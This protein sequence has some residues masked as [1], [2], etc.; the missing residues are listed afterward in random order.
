MKKM[1]CPAMKS[2]VSSLVSEWSGPT[3]RHDPAAEPSPYHAVTV[4]SRESS[5]VSVAN[6]WVVGGLNTPVDHL[7]DST[8]RCVVCIPHAG[9]QLHIVSVSF[10]PVS[11]RSC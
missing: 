8:R 3:I 10:Q 2:V 4:A 1:L 6:T 5:P 9:Q 11:A 7:C